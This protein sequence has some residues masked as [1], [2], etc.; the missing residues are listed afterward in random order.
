MIDRLSHFHLH[1]GRFIR[2]ASGVLLIAAAALLLLARLGLTGGSILTPVALFL[3][4]WL[5]WGAF[6]LFAAFAA[7]GAVLIRPPAG[8]A[9]WAR[10]FALE[11]AAL[12]A[13]G[14][15]SIA[16][17]SSLVRADAGLD[18]GRLGWGIAYALRTYLGFIGGSS[19]LIA[20]VLVFGSAGLGLFGHL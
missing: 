8:S 16:G 1:F 12:M 19:L 6:A 15:L 18:G 2:D 9:P 10:I 17:G 14:L 20:L 13:L 7:I 3:S 5:G 11:L 4:T